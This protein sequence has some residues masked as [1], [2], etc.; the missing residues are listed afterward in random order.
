MMVESVIHYY[1]IT[2][3]WHSWILNAF[4]VNKV[5][6]SLCRSSS[7]QN[8]NR[9]REDR[10]EKHKVNVLEMHGE[11]EKVRLLGNSHDAPSTS[12]A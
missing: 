4:G 6:L 1:K 5:S 7:W 2:V 11:G 9:E 3:F 12:K 8:G 10:E